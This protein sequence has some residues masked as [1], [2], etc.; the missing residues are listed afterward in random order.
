MQ[1]DELADPNANKDILKN[2]KGLAIVAPSTQLTS[3]ELDHVE[4]VWIDSPLGLPG[5][6]G[7]LV[8]TMQKSIGHPL[9]QL[10]LQEIRSSI[11]RY[12]QEH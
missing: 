10:D 4:G 7:E 5:N 12:Y 1:Y 2:L 11:A 3:G 8:S 6:E 9:T